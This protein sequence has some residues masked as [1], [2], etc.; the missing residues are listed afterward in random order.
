[1]NAIITKST[2]PQNELER[3]L[4]WFNKDA[5]RRFNEDRYIAK[6]EVVK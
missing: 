4:K 6:C 3:Y 1:M 2:R 5:L